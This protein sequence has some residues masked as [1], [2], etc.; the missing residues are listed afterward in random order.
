ME[1]VRTIERIKL[2][3]PVI[4]DEV[5]DLYVHHVVPAL[6]SNVFCRFVYTL[7][8]FKE[9]DE[10]YA[11]GRTKLFDNNGKRLGIVT[12]ANGGKSF[13]NYGLAFDIVLVERSNGIWDIV[14]DYDGD[15]KSDWMEVVNIFLSR[16]WEWGGNFKKIPIDAPHLQKTFNF[17]W[18]QLLE[19]YNKN[20]TFSFNN[21]TYINL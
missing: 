19:K 3:H 18:Q 21:I 8:T 20:D 16:G 17:T 13:H 14:K 12:N 11:Q 15:G 9:Q 6:S 10:L 5:M 4:V 1:D 7:R 2:L